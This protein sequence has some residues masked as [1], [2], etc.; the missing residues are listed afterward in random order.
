MDN[1]G[2]LL[3]PDA[4]IESIWTLFEGGPCSPTLTE[5][6]CVPRASHIFLSHVYI[7]APMRE[8]VVS[9][10]RVRLIIALC[11]PFV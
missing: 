9:C 8:Y 5:F 2:D 3:L 1:A 10:F 6:I 7:L 11:S 4:N